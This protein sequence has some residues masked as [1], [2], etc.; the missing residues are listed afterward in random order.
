LSVTLFTGACACVTSSTPLKPVPEG[1]VILRFAWPEHLSARVTHTLL[2]NAAGAVHHDQQSLCDDLQPPAQRIVQARCVSCHAARPTRQQSAKIHQQTVQLK[3][4]LLAN[5]TD[6]ERAVIDA[7][8][9]TDA[10]Q[11][12]TPI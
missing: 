2:I 4:M 8:F 3:A 1:A 9:A 5:M 11:G 7:W 6:E 12:T 10:T